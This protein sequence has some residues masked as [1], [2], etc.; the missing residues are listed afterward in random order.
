MS[1]RALLAALPVGLLFC[2]G[3]SG[4]GGNTSPGKGTGGGPVTAATPI[5]LAANQTTTGVDIAVVSPASSPTPN[6]IA[7]GTDGQ[8]AFSTGGTV[9]RGGTATII[10]FG[11]GLSSSMQ[12]SISG[13]NDITM[14]TV[15]SVTATDGTPGV[16]FPITVGSS[17][18]LGA[19]T[20]V[21]QDTNNNITTFTG[22]LEVLP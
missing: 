6:V 10:A 20:L 21:M 16:A 12:I 2:I 11:A 9:N 7:L 19:R 14:G 8:S 5:T 18:A 3:C 13:P 4:G 17:A 1:W 22:G 15:T